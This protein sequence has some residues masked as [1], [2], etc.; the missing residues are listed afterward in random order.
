MYDFDIGGF[1]LSVMILLAVLAVGLVAVL[2]MWLTGIR[3][4]WWM[5]WVLIGAAGMAVVSGIVRRLTK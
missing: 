5:L 3:P 2:V 4:D 1:I